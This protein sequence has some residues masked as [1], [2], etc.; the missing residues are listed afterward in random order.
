MN[1]VKWMGAYHGWIDGRSKRMCADVASGWACDC[2]CIDGP[3]GVGERL[4]GVF[5]CMNACG[6]VVGECGR[7]VC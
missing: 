5:V 1:V 6:G 4:G 2:G 7:S 3:M